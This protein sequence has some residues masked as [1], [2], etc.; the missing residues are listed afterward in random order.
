MIVQ[1]NKAWVRL[2]MDNQELS[3]DIDAFT[4]DANVDASK[5]REWHLHGSNVSLLGL[6][7]AYWF[8]WWGFLPEGTD[9]PDWVLD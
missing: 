5:L 4:A 7:K 8:K 6:R 2:V 9:S 1:Q 3:Q